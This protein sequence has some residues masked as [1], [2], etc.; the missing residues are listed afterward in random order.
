MYDA[1]S[2]FFFPWE[3]HRKSRYYS[4]WVTGEDTG[5]EAI[6]SSGGRDHTSC[7]CDLTILLHL[8]KHMRQISGKASSSLSFETQ[9]QSANILPF[10]FKSLQDLSSGILKEYP[11]PCD[12]KS[13]V[14]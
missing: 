7:S 10:N 14:I 2:Q 1:S 12:H 6:D 4:H 3:V 11:D 5:L 8:L 9:L 13:L